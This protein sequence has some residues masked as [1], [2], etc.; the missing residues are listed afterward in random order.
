M[1]P[2]RTSKRENENIAPEEDEYGSMQ[3]RIEE[4][5]VIVEQ[6]QN[7]LSS[8]LSILNAKNKQLDEKNKQLDELH[9][10]VKMMKQFTLNQI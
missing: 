6:Q 8:V 7:D 5:E 2:L 9:L 10:E 3:N 4:L 1:Y